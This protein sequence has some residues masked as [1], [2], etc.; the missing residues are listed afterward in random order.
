MFTKLNDCIYNSVGRQNYFEEAKV[1]TKIK[2]FMSKLNQKS[3]VKTSFDLWR[4]LLTFAQLRNSIVLETNTN[5]NESKILK[6]LKRKLGLLRTKN[7][8]QTN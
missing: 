8:T 4:N 1:K 3:K 2:S 7:Q 6:S 5:Y